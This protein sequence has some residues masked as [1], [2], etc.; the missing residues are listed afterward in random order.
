MAAVPTPRRRLQDLPAIER[1]EVSAQ[2][3]EAVRASEWDRWEWP[4]ILKSCAHARGL[5]LDDADI[6]P[7]LARV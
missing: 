1:A 7:I 5:R 3:A 6:A 4:E 2:L